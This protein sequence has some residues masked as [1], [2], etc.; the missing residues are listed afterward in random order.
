MKL[1]RVVAMR[2]VCCEVKLRM[3]G[4]GG[5][6]AGFLRLGGQLLRSMNFNAT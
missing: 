1:G 3:R 4:L 6:V 2:T 5:S